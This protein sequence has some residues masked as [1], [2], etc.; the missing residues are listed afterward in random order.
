[1]FFLPAASGERISLAVTLLLAMTV[2]MLVIMENIPETS[3]TVPSLGDIYFHRS[4]VVV[5]VSGV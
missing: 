1:M 2:F 4:E 3:E 5:T